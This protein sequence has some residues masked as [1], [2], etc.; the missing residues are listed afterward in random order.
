M[1][2][3]VNPSL[4]RAPLIT[5]VLIQKYLQASVHVL[6]IQC[7]YQ[8]IATVLSGNKGAAR[9]PLARV[10]SSISGADH[11]GGKAWV[12][13]LALGIGRHCNIDFL[14]DVGSPAVLF[15]GSPTSDSCKDTVVFGLKISGETSRAHFAGELDRLGQN[16]D[17][18]VI[19][20][21]PRVEVGVLDDLSNVDSVDLPVG[22]VVL[23]D[24]HLDPGWP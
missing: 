24:G 23:S 11:V 13:L 6:D 7:Y 2:K 15:E 5:R 14:K 10:L 18:I 22:D 21:C 4:L 17:G 1:W 16:K 9:I 3:F 12:S 19:V 20:G 8:S